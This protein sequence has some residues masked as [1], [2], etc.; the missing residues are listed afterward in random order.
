MTVLVTGGMGYI[1]S[2]TCVELLEQGMD[3]VVVDNLVNSSAE[4]GRRVEQ[5]TGR[6]L[7]FYQMDVRDRAG[8]DRI[9]TE[10]KIDCVIHFAGLKAVGESVQMP[11]E[12]YDNNLGSTITLCEAMR[13]HGVRQ[14]IF[15]SSATVYSGDNE[16]PLYETSRTGNC[17]NPY[18]WTKYVCEQ[19]LR[20]YVVADP[21]WSVVLLRYF[22]PIGGHPSGLLGD[23]PNGIPNN[24]M[25]YIARVA[26]GQLDKLTIFGDDYP[27]PDG[28]CRRDYLHVVDLAKGH[29]KA[30]D[31][32]MEHT[33][34]EAFNLGTGHAVSVLELMN[35]F[36]EATGVNVP[37]VIG[38]RREGDLPQMWADTHKAETVLGWKAEKTVADMCRDSWNFV[39]SVKKQ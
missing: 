19:I 12:Y 21:S 18:G 28:T 11:L 2:H 32:A 14:I 16:M 25:P 39:C 4:A 15:S 33:G 22:N 17:T 31:Y 10:Q 13:D 7:K 1:G 8:L 35:T 38:P 30:I 27:T 29:L 20:D 5:I 26:A 34:A 36:M 9:F 24:L 37:Y 23:D 6:P 3:V